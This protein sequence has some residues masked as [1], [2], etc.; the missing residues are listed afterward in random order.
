MLIV[1]K[2]DPSEKARCGWFYFGVR[3][4]PENKTIHFRIINIK[5]WVHSFKSRKP[6]WTFSCKNKLTDDTGW[7]NDKCTDI[8]FEKKNPGIYSY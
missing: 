2:N 8:L 7:T 1:L 4:L 6:V 3:N 5:M